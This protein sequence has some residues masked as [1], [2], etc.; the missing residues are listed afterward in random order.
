MSVQKRRWRRLAGAG[1][2]AT[3][4]AVVGLGAV[5]GAAGAEGEQRNVPLGGAK[6]AR[7]EVRLDA[8]E[9]KL[10]GGAAATD[11]LSGTF[12][13]EAD[14]GKPE[15]DYT[16]EEGR[17]ELKV[18]PD[19]GGVHITWPW[20]MVDDTKWDVAINDTVATDL[21]VDVDA[22]KLDLALG[23]T[24]VSNLEVDADAAKAE[25]DL[26]G[27]WSHDLTADLSADAGQ[28]VVTVPAEVGVRVEAKV[29]AGDKDIDGLQEIEDDVY[30][31]DAYATATVKLTIKANVDAGQLK[32]QVAD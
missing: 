20:D 2:A 6:S 21:K 10:H 26:S 25:V 3:L 5:V 19:G 18:K 14:N 28:L 16:V 24:A 31:N 9:L 12:D 23:G 7:V 29:E 13:Y 30:V 1:V 4:V 11:L 22:G 32:V 27:P 17:G 15:F 8:G